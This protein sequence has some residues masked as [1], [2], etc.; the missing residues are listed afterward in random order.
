MPK[1]GAGANGRSWSLKI[2]KV[3]A[4]RGPAKEGICLAPPFDRTG[5]ASEVAG[6]VDRSQDPK[7]TRGAYRGIMIGRIPESYGKESHNR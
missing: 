3:N 5:G 1:S 7:F 4:F 6:S 2:D